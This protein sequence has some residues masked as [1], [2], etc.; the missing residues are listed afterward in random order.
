MAGRE[1][2]ASNLAFGRFVALLRKLA[3]RERATFVY[4]F[5]EGMTVAQVAVALNVSEPTAR[6]SFSRAYARM[7][8]WAARD[9]FLYDYLQRRAFGSPWQAAADEEALADVPE[10]A[11]GERALSD[12][13]AQLA[14]AGAGAKVAGPGLLVAYGRVD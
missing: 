3:E 7:Q 5:V 1:Q 12:D 14:F 2:P 8:K 11:D 4:R 6:R 10:F 13:F 9:P